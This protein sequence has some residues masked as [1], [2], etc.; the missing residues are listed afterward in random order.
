MN[1]QTVQVLKDNQWQEFFWK[2]VQVGD[3]ILVHEGDSICA[4]SVLWNS[5]L[6]GGQAFVLT[7]NLDSE[8]SLRGRQALK[9]TTV[10]NSPVD[11]EEIQSFFFSLFF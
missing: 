6:P 8:T 11:L 9:N 1:H 2:D 4:D 5:S 3:F 7:V 10:F